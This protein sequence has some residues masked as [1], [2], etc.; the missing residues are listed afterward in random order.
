M[1]LV[2]ISVKQDLY[3]QIIRTI[4]DDDIN[5]FIDRTLRSAMK[6][7]AETKKEK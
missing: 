1:K 2:M 4:E 7:K 6:M 5:A 3:N